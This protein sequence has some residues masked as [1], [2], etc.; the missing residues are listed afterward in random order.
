[1]KRLSLAAAMLCAAAF[2]APASADDPIQLTISGHKFEPAEIKVPAG[3]EVTL[4]VINKDAEAEEFESHDLD[5]EKVIAGGQQATV[6]IRALDAG[7]YEF[8]GEY[9]EDTAKGV[10]IAE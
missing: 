7:K 3:K 10:L 9:H 6:T 2:S 1:M 5:I 4:L 8:V